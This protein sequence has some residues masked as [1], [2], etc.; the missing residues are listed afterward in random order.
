MATRR[1]LP[2]IADHG[3]GSERRS[4]SE[5][6]KPGSEVEIVLDHTPFYAEAGGQV[7]DTGHFLAPG[8]GPRSGAC[9]HIRIIP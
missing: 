3:V 5:K 2:P 6:Y 7:G 1:R 8:S 4:L 9:S